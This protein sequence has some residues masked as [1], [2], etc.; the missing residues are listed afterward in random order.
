MTFQQNSR[1]LCHFNNT[2]LYLQNNWTLRY[3]RFIG[4]EI[5]QTSVL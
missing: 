4:G 2:E 3:F 1:T 5:I